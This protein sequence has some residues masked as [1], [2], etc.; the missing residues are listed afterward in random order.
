LTEFFLKV[1]DMLD[2]Y[3]LITIPEGENLFQ[4]KKSSELARDVQN[5]RKWTCRKRG[6]ICIPM[7]TAGLES[8]EPN[9]S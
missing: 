8:A 4:A 9:I 5:C 2:L 1:D 3:L 7:K 6:T